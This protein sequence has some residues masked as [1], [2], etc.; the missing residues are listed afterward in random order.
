MHQH[1]PSGAGVHIRGILIFALYILSGTCRFSL[2]QRPKSSTEW[3]PEWATMLSVREAIKH[4]ELNIA[5]GHGLCSPLTFG[6]LRS[7]VGQPLTG[8]CVLTL[9][10]TPVTGTLT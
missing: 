2:N 5:T 10:H 8:R 7:A 1:Q 4:L 6:V 9:Q 3:H